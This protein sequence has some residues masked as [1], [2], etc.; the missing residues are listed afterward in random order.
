MLARQLNLIK[1]LERK[2]S[3]RIKY[4]HVEVAHFVKVTGNGQLNRVS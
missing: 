1:L 2:T 4:F 3:F